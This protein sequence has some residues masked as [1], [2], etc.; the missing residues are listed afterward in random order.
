MWVF[1]S[2]ASTQAVCGTDFGKASWISFIA[3]R[4]VSSGS[5]FISPMVQA[6]KGSSGC[7]RSVRKASIIARRRSAMQRE[8]LRRSRWPRLAAR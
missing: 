5:G 4:F 3:L 6:M 2:R 8:F 1:K 7:A